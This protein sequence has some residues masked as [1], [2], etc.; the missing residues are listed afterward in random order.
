MVP[1]EDLALLGAKSS[2]GTVI[3]MRPAFYGEQNNYWWLE[4]LN[5]RAGVKPFEK[6]PDKCKYVFDPY[7][8]ALDIN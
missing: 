5:N 1:A 6:N 8:D 7:M 2:V 3:F 4:E